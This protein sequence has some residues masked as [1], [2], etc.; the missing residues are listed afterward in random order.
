MENVEN[1]YFIDENKYNCPFCKN[2]GIKYVVLGI[3]KFDESNTK[4]LYAV[5]VECSHCHKISM[6]LIKND[7]LG[8][9]STIESNGVASYPVNY[10]FKLTGNYTNELRTYSGNKKNYIEGW[11]LNKYNIETGDENEKSL[12]AVCDDNTIILNIPSSFFT[13]DERISR[14]LRDLIEEA[15]KCIKNNCLTGASACIRKAI[16]EFLIKEEAIGESYEDKMKSL[17]GKYKLLDDD[18]IDMLV[19]IQGIMCD[20]VHEQSI[21][22]KFSSQEAKA[23]IE[24]LKEIFNQVYV[25]PEKLKKQKNKICNLYGS[26]KR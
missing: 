9:F 18:Y 8:E 16:Y 21:H 13:I 15:E 25:V 10:N 26:I 19:G 6:H 12:K 2:R 17:K 7:K 5:F 14:K 4:Q 23:Y 3:V 11:G 22:E 1:K 20:Q 24:V